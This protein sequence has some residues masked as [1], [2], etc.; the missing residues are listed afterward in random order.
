MTAGEA[1]PIDADAANGLFV[2]ELTVRTVA[3]RRIHQAAWAK[4]LLIERKHPIALDAHTQDF[5]VAAMLAS[6]PHKQST[7]E[8]ASVLVAKV[9]PT[10]QTTLVK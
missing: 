1:V 4:L 5:A 2:N 6:A 10:L 8:T 9:S 7:I 3:E